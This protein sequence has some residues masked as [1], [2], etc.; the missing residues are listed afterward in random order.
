MHSFDALHRFNLAASC[1]ANNYKYNLI[2]TAY[3]VE[4]PKYATTLYVLHSSGR[5]SDVSVEKIPRSKDWERRS[6]TCEPFWL[7]EVL[8]VRHASGESF[9]DIDHIIPACDIA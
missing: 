5:E 3:E 9:N 4:H 1:L 7:G 2:I 6:H 8:I